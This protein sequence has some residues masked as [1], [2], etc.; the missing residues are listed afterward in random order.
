MSSLSESIIIEFPLYETPS[1][2]NS[3][4]SSAKPAAI[5]YSVSSRYCLS[6]FFRSEI[7]LATIVNVPA[8]SL[9]STSSIR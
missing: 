3:T 4:P 2:S 6:A 7:P 1:S 5:L 9:S 8:T